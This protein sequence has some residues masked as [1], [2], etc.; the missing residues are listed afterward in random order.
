MV[1]VLVH[2]LVNYAVLLAAIRLSGRRFAGQFSPLDLLFIVLLG[3]A[4][5]TSMVARNTTLPAGLVSAATL[6]VLT[7]GVATLAQSSA[8]VDRVLN[9]APL[10][11]VHDGHVLEDHLAQARLTRDALMRG[12]RQRGYAHLAGVR[13]VVLEVD[14]DINVIP[15]ET[16]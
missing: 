4:V 11:L 9:G 5:E 16:A 14:G 3:S 7:W 8:A 10:L 2:T 6:L 13:E 12:L 1:R 15:E